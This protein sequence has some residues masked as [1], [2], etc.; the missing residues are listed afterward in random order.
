[1]ADSGPKDSFPELS[2]GRKMKAP[3]RHETAVA[4]MPRANLKTRLPKPMRRKTC[5]GSEPLFWVREWF[6]MVGLASVLELAGMFVLRDK[7]QGNCPSACLSITRSNCFP[8]L[9]LRLDSKHVKHSETYTL[10]ACSQVLFLREWF[11][12]LR[13]N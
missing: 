8:V 9:P 4:Q 11:P 12:R 3:R 6:T 2:C 10:R 13:V 7:G 1:M 5:H